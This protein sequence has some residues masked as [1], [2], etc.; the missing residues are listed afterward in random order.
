MDQLSIEINGLVFDRADSDAESDVLY[1]ARG[2][3]QASSDAALTPEGH[4]IRYGPS[5]EVIAVRIVNARSR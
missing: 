3:G 5:G 4:G 1:L 2:D